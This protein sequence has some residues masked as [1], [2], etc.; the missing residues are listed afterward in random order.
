VQVATPPTTSEFRG[1]IIGVTLRPVSGA[2]VVSPITDE[3]FLHGVNWWFN[4]RSRSLVHSPDTWALHLALLQPATWRIQG[5]LMTG[6]SAVVYWIDCVS[7]AQP[8]GHPHQDW[9]PG[10]GLSIEPED[11]MALRPDITVRLD[12]IAWR[13][14][15]Y[16]VYSDRPDELLVQHQMLV[17]I[18]S[19]HCHVFMIKIVRNQF[20]RLFQPALVF[21]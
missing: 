2:D 10:N 20:L 16:S 15:I 7:S 9:H 13:E 8:L 1:G 18:S 3:H 21:S 12:F 14:F 11:C 5:M 19:A 17:I 6:T 4:F